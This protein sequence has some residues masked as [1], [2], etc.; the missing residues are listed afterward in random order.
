M[1]QLRLGLRE[2]E[3]TV[4]NRDGDESYLARLIRLLTEDLDFHELDSSYA[5][6]NMHAFPAKFPPQL[7]RKFI[8]ILTSPGEIVLDPMMGSGTTILEAFLTG[9]QAYGL[10]IDP[11]AI[12]VSKVKT[13]PLDVVEVMRAGNHVVHRAR[14]ALAETTEDRIPELNHWD[15]ATRRFVNYWFAKETQQ[16]LSA[17][18]QEIRKVSDIHIRNFLKLVLSSTIITKMGGVSL[19]LDLAHTRPHRAKL[20]YDRDGDVLFDYGI[21]SIPKRRKRYVTKTLR[22]PLEEFGKRLQQNSHS[23]LTPQSTDLPPQISFGNAQTM[24]LRNASVDLIATSPPY[25]SNAIDY[26]RAHKFSL[27]WFGHPVDQLSDKRGEYIGGEAV[28]DFGFCKLPDKTAS[29][30]AEVAE[31]DEKKGLVLHRYYSE[32]THVLREMLRVLKPGKAAIV[33]VGSSKMRER[34]TETERC[35]AEIGEALGFSVP[36]IGVRNLDRNRRMMPAGTQVDQESQIQQRMHE[37]YVIGFYKPTDD[38]E[39]N[40]GEDS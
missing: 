9:R 10:D 4:Q 7:P 40:D 24:P 34:D 26:M 33:V 27:V 5:S 16:E 37:E 11:L 36:K 30:V 32:M 28:S 31:L 13:Q 12:L 2:S 14:K 1:Q 3:R 39:G 18:I 25:A 29:V 17:L 19:G 6:H 22:S 35:L 38:S 21:D 8:D 23:L 20:V 15:K